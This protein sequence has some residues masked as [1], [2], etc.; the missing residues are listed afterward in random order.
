MLCSIPAALSVH[1]LLRFQRMTESAFELARSD[2]SCI[3]RRSLNEGGFGGKRPA[4]LGEAPDFRVK[5]LLFRSFFALFLFCFFGCVL[6]RFWCP[7]GCLLGSLLGLFAA[8]VGPKSVSE[9]HFF[10]KCVFSNFER[11]SRETSQ[12]HQ[13]TSQEHPKTFP[14]RS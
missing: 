3:P 1:L 8:Q 4:W 12:E 2:W 11:H 7:F 10:K 6:G 9:G 5:G 13:K 14:R